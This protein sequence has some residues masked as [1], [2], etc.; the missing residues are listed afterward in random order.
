VE[1]RATIAQYRRYQED[2]RD[3]KAKLDETIA[4]EQVKKMMV[5]KDWLAVGEQQQKDHD[6]FSGMRRECATTARW[7][8]HHETIK[9][10]MD[11]DVPNTPTVW[12]HGIPG[13]GRLYLYASSSCNSNTNQA[14]LFSLLLSS[15]NA[16]SAKTSLP[17]TSIAMTAMRRATL[18]LAY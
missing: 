4:K 3:L 7:I 13:A 16:D 17:V 9:H 1:C 6:N 18:Q 14:K 5:V 15:T 2:I 12:V 10:W 8:L 11:A